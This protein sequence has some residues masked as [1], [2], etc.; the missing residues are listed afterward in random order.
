MELTL[1]V[2]GVGP[3]GYFTSTRRKALLIYRVAWAVVFPIQSVVVGLFDDFDPLYFVVNAVILVI[4]IGL[5]RLGSILRERRAA[6][7][8]VVAETA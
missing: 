2:L 8:R 1:A 5:N 3:T 7:R 4:G 6:E